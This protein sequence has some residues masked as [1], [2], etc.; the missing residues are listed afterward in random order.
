MT[1]PRHE[2][3]LEDL[4]R[5]EVRGGLHAETVHHHLVGVDLFLPVEVERGPND[6]RSRV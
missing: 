6:P 3:L 2:R 4:H 1:P 5:L